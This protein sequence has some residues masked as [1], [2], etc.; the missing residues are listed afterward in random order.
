MKMNKVLLKKK[1]FVDLTQL[2]LVYKFYVQ[3]CFDSVFIFMFPY[4]NFTEI[5]KIKRIYCTNFWCYSFSS[6]FTR[7]FTCEVL[8]F[9]VQLPLLLSYFLIL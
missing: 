4:Q 2:P 6:S 1:G 8:C 5:E 9:L 3:T 7:L